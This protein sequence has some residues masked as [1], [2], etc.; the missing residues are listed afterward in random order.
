MTD[1]AQTQHRK[2]TP[3][4]VYSDRMINN[5]NE[6]YKTTKNTNIK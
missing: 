5:K 4:R 2:D 3:W 1:L 6:I